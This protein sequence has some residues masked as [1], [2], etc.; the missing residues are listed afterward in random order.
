MGRC[1]AHRVHGSELPAEPVSQLIV[2]LGESDTLA[3]MSWLVALLCE[4][5]PRLCAL[6][7]AALDPATPAGPEA[8]SEAT[9]EAVDSPA[10]PVGLWGSP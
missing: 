3:S 1:T 2:Q 7:D 4:R 10:G 6:L 5:A 8:A 9:A